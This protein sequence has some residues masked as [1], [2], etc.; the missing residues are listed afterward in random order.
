MEKV[1]EATIS[2]RPS[3]KK[4]LHYFSAIGTGWPDGLFSCQKFKFGYILEGLEME[5]IGIFYDHLEYFAAICYTYL[6]AILYCWVRLEYFP[7]FGMFGPRKI[8]QPCIE[9]V[10]F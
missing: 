5:N 6:T 4:F 10:R 9:S 3:E 8:W 1:E 2:A 7:R